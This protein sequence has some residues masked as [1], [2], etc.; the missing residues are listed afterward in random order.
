MDLID[1]ITHKPRIGSGNGRM[2]PAELER[3]ATHEAGHALAMFLSGTGGSD[4]GYVTIV[5]RDDGTLGFVA[6]LP[7]ERVHRTRRDYEDELDVWLA[8]RAAEEVI[9]GADEITTGAATDLQNATELVTRMVTQL[10]LGRG[11]GLLWSATLSAADLELA[12][13]T[14]TESYER[15]L[16]KL[17]AERT[18]LK[19]L[20]KALAARQELPGNDVLAIFGGNAR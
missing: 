1:E 13:R 7:D 5:P 17:K 12:D 18:K 11:R 10:G 20:A 9:Y 19:K 6:P 8:G 15:V 3:T 2:T 16:G 14:L 4:I